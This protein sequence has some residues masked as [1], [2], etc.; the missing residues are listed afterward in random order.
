MN[1]A[2]CH[3]PINWFA[4]QSPVEFINSMHDS[5]TASNWGNWFWPGFGALLTYGLMLARTRFA[6]FPLHPIGY[7]MCLSY[8]MYMFWFSILLGWL[9][10]GLISAELRQNECGPASART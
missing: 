3:R 6:G 10:K 9:C 4:A 8:P 1:T 2:V 5:S 7:V